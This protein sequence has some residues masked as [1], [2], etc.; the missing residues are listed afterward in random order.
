[1]DLSIHKPISIYRNRIA[2]LLLAMAVCSV[3]AAER[4]EES[5]GTGLHPMWDFGMGVS[6][7]LI[8][9]VSKALILPLARPRENSYFGFP[10]V[11]A[12]HANLD[13][14]LGGAML[15]GGVAFPSRG[16]Y[17]GSALS[18]K[19]AVLRPWLLNVGV[20]PNHTYTGGLVELLVKSHPDGKVGLGYFRARDPLHASPNGFLYVYMGVGL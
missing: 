20:R 19:A 3:A 17:Q 7:P 6:Y 11:P 9:S 5:N 15:S 16:G 10:G 13:V 2:A 4:A 14:G 1:M 18:L 12:L 8:L